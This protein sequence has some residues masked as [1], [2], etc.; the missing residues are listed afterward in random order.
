[1]PQAAAGLCFDGIGGT[2]RIELTF[3]QFL[4]N[5]CIEFHVGV[6]LLTI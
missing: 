1:M 3:C 6:N 4:Y 2:I 5:Q